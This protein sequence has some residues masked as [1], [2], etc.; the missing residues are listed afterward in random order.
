MNLKFW[1]KCSART[2]GVSS[3]AVSA[4]EAMTPGT[5][6]DAMVRLLLQNREKSR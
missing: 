6:S 3:A 4:I 5:A 1:T 2:T